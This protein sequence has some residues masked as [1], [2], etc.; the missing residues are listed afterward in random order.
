MK[1]SLVIL[2]LFVLS[3]AGCR[4]ITG[5]GQNQA[6]TATEAA[7][8][9]SSINHIVFMVQENRSFDHYFGKLGEYRQRFG[10]GSA[11]DIDGLSANPVNPT[12][13]GSYVH[14][15]HLDTTCI[16][17]LSPDWLESHADVNRDHPGSS[18]MPM[19]GFVINSAKYAQENGELDRVGARAMGYYDDAD[20]PYYYYMAS[21]FG[22]SDRW[23][24]PL[25]SNSI[26][27]RIFL[28]AASTG[29]HV[30]EPNTDGG[31]CCDNLN[32]IFNLLDAAKVSWKIY[33][34]DTQANGQPLTDINN[35]WPKF[36]AAHTKNIVPVAEY[37]TDLQNGTLPAVAFVQA[38]LG[39][40]RDEHPGGQVVEGQGGND[41]QLGARYAA[42]IINALMFSTAWNDSAF[43]L[44]FD[45]GGSFYDHVPPAPAVVPDTT[46]IMDLRAT[47]NVIQPQGNFDRTG[48]RLPLIVVSPYAKKSYVSHTTADSTAIIKF[49]ETRFGLGSMSRRDASQ[50]NMLEFFDF[51]NPPWMTAPIPPDQPVQGRCRPANIPQTTTPTP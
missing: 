34:S 32:N 45:E 44:T 43:I 14:S 25:M 11:K 27:N 7:D 1:H 48:F 38:G 16:E 10:Y 50:M 28:Q 26:P 40:G 37:F 3:L 4:G 20:L 42:E 41:I 46:K 17:E 24:S 36:A 8:L 15:Y 23:F 9:R 33:Y 47:D 22:T 39:S 19:D 21:N 12:L 13:D 51:K 49:I 5:L 6:V 31:A 30:H 35:Y 18:A 2:L 29:G